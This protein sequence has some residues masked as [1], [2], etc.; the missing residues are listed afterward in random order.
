N[1]RT[2]SENNGHLSCPFLVWLRNFH[3]RNCEPL[4][5]ELI[6]FVFALLYRLACEPNELVAEDRDDEIFTGNFSGTTSYTGDKINM[7]PYALIFYHQGDEDA[8]REDF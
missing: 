4:S 2:D 5:S 3:P 1:P 8:Q 6:F 7:Q